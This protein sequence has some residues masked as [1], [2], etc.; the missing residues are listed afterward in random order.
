MRFKYGFIGP[1][2]PSANEIPASI[3]D[4]AGAYKVACQFE[5]HP[6][7]RAAPRSCGYYSAKAEIAACPRVSRCLKDIGEA[8]LLAITRH[9]AGILSVPRCLGVLR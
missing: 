3:S 9:F 5:S 2:E 4:R 8:A 6:L 7:R 1:S